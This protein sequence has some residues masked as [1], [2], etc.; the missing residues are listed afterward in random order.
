MELEKYTAKKSVQ[1]LPDRPKNSAAEL[2]A[3]FD[4]A[5]KNI[6]EYINE[7]LIPEI[8][9][10]QESIDTKTSKTEIVDNLESSVVDAPLSANQGRVLNE[11]IE[12]YKYET[13]FVVNEWIIDAKKEIQSKLDNKVDKVDNMFL[14]AIQNMPA[15]IGNPNSPWVISTSDG[16]GVE[17]YNAYQI[18][19]KFTDLSGICV[20]YDEIVDN[21]ESSVSSIP[22]S[23]NQGRVLNEKIGD[24]DEALEE[25]IAIQNRLMGVSE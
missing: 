22:L 20:K 18:D 3:V 16:A 25:I 9:N 2:K 19:S 12:H 10:M 23:A 17:V 5:E 14:T 4:E 24:I 1:G 15:I 7:K 6:G 21:L 13:E 11:K 8:E